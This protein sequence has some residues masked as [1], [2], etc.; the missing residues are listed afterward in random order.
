[1]IVTHFGAEAFKLQVGDTVVSLN[2]ISKDSKL[3]PARFG[4]DVVL[5]SIPHV[6]MNGPEQNEFGDKKPFVV[7]GPGEYEVQ[8]IFI[9]GFGSE[10]M[11]GGEKLY[12]T[13][14]FLTLDGIK[15]CFLG[16]LGKPELPN[17]ALESA[18]EIDMLFVPIGGDGVLTASEAGKL[19]V[20]L[21][22][23]LI[24]PMH[25]SGI[26]SKD[27]LKTFLK[28]VGKDVKEED[29]LTVKKKDLEGKVGEVCVLSAQ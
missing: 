7:S 10:S 20:S 25:W 27:A 14:Y 15:M 22:P 2:P 18:E 26:G 4:A 5:S 19:A 11:Y 17:E 6:D 29:K 21:E 8:G 16:A 24:I 3:K 23:K 12:N 9:K 1:M 13:V 28:E